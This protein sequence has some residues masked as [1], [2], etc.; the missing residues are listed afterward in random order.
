MFRAEEQDDCLQSQAEAESVQDVRHMKKRHVDIATTMQSKVTEYLQGITD[1]EFRRMS[2][3]AAMRL[4]HLAI[5][6][7]RLARGVPD[8]PDEQVV[9]ILA[10]AIRVKQES[11]DGE[12]PSEGSPGS[13]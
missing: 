1:Q 12:W 9:E 5:K 10:E 6:N 2:P 8:G 13:T 11:A 4:L 3:D 7:E